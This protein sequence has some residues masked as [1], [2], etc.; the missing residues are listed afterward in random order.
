MRITENRNRITS[1]VSCPPKVSESKF[2]CSPNEANEPNAPRDCGPT[3][4]NCSASF[5]GEAYFLMLCTMVVAVTR[6]L[7]TSMAVAAT[8]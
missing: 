5:S 6:A 7:T 2:N 4:A 8:R 3:G 1:S